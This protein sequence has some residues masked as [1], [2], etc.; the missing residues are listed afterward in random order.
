MYS[1]GGILYVFFIYGMYWML[2][3]VASHKEDPQAVLIR[4]FSGISGPG[5]ITRTTGIDGSY[6]GEDLTSSTR[7]WLTEKKHQLEYVALPRVGIG[8]AGDPWVDKPWR[9]MAL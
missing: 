9:F 7:I 2:N 6:Y 3:I 4:G 5:R 8:Y 1:E